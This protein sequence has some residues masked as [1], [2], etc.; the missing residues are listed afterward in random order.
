[1]TEFDRRGKKPPERNRYRLKRVERRLNGAITGAITDH[2]ALTGLADDDHPQYTT[3]AEAT[4]IADS[5]VTT[6]E[7]AGDPHPQYTTAAEVA[8]G[9]QPLDSDLTAI[10]A[11]APV[12]D[13]I[14][15]RKAGAW[16]NRTMAQL[17]VDLSLSGTNTGDQTS[18]VGITGTLAEFNAALTGADFATGGGTATGTNTGDQTSIV[19]ITGT[20][21][22]FNTA[23]T[24]AD[25]LSTAAAAA[26][27]QPL[28]T[29]LTN[30]AAANWAANSL[31][32]GSGADTVAQV[33][34]AAGTFP[35]RGTAGNLVA[36]SI[37][38][39]ALAFLAA[40]NDAAMRTELGLGTAAVKNTGTSGDAIPLLNTAVDW[41]AVSRW[42]F[43]NST[44][45]NEIR[46]AGGGQTAITQSHGG[47]LLAATTMNA[48]NK[49]TIGVLFA[50]LDGDFT[51]TNPKLGAAIVGVATENYTADTAGG[52][53]I[54]FFGQVNAPGA[55]PTDLVSMGTALTSG[56]TINLATG[57]TAVTQAAGD[58]S[59]KISTTAYARAA[60]PNSSYRTII[61]RTG[62][63]IA[64]RVAGT[65]AVPMGDPLPITGTGTLYPWGA[66]YYDP[67]DHP[68]VDGLAPKL[69]LRAQLYVNDTAPTGNFTFG[70]HPITRSGATGGAGLNLSTIGAAVAGS[71]VAVNTPAADSSNT[72]TGTDF[73]APAA[74]H[75]VIG[76]VTTATVAASSHLHISAQL[77]MR[78]N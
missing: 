69:R 51:T 8:A 26:T 64:G 24:D 2:G 73:A 56:W 18:I 36:K 70:L 78:N 39:D 12:N 66:F 30:L 43:G 52:M 15:Q 19:G 1:L 53:G 68:T 77:Q 20:L 32:I 37:S 28:D 38:D 65:Y 71:T 21:A 34:F 45:R 41:S 27:Y 5:A 35:A 10:A 48:T 44:T 42:L 58:N 55:G 6:H 60:A 59:T 13:D 11:L 7:A 46:S 40:A 63:H 33:T 67:A 9:Y 57:A 74:G 62:S 17:K 3:H 4:T 75:Y 29:T 61:D 23:I 50:A 14:L 49:Y 22:Q 47:L 16:T 31:A 25:I 76:V 54:E 72:L